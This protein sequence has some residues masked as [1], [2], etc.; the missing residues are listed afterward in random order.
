M[1]LSRTW[2]G[3]SRRSQRHAATGRCAVWMCG[4]GAVA[5]SSIPHGGARAFRA[6]FASRIE[7]CVLSVGS[8]ALRWPRGVTHWREEARR[9]SRSAVIDAQSGDVLGTTGTR[10]LGYCGASAA[11]TGC[12]AL[13]VHLLNHHAGRDV[14]VR[15]GRL[16]CFCALPHK[17]RDVMDLEVFKCLR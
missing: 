1:L 8:A 2:T 4:R 7:H 9:P 13:R 14:A 3:I 12:E 5:W 16:Y 6:V 11:A 17:L 15:A 10:T